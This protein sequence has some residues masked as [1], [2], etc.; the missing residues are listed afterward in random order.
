MQSSPQTPSAPDT[1]EPSAAR[2]ESDLCDSGPTQ[3]VVE[4]SPAKPRLAPGI[5]MAALASAVSMALAA[6]AA[7]LGAG[8]VSPLIISLVLGAIVGSTWRVPA[9]ARPGTAWTARRVLRAG[10]VLLGLDLS[11]RELLGIGWA[12][13]VVIV[14]TVACTFTGT[15]LVGRLMGVAERTRLYVATGF[16]ICGAAAIA[17]ME[18]TMSEIDQAQTRTEAAAVRPEAA[19]VPQDV[20]KAQAELRASAREA[21]NANALGTSLALVAIYGALMVVLLPWLTG[22]IGLND[23]DAGLWIGAST[24]EVAHVVAAGGLVSSAALAVATISKL[25]RVVLL[26]PLVTII[27]L[28]VGRWQRRDGQA[29]GSGPL[30]DAGQPDAQPSKSRKAP[31]VPVFVI[32]F[33]AAIL[34]RSTGLV[35]DAALTV[36]SNISKALLTAAMF[37]LGTTIDIPVLL[38]TGRSALVLG[39]ISTAIAVLVSLV[40]VLLLA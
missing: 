37:A 15:L 30:V 7:S 1:S 4:P 9:V 3:A 36:A 22:L 21:T 32:G 13:A 24:H 35:P 31:L 17:A 33:L 26:A 11:L 12:G 14:V 5:A 27:S 8:F 40:G 16:S 19:D 10:I 18:A 28:V 29:I 39:A 34:V 23:H 2:A 20:Q 6:L 38:R 25:G